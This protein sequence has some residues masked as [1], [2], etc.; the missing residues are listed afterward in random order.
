MLQAGPFTGNFAGCYQCSA[1]YFGTA[2]NHT[3][4]LCEAACWPGH[5]CLEGSTA[6]S[7]C[8]AGTYLPAPG[9]AT[10]ASCIPCAPGSF[11]A[12][13][14]NGNQSCTPC[15]PGTFSSAPRATNCSLCEPGG[16]CASVGAASASMTFEPCPG[17]FHTLHTVITTTSACADP[18]LHHAWQLASTIRTL[19]R[20]A[21]RRAA[22]A[23]PARPTQ[24][25]AAE[26]HLCAQT[27]SQGAS[28][29]Q[30]ARPRALHALLAR[31]RTP[32]AQPYAWNVLRARTVRGGHGSQGRRTPSRTYAT[33]CASRRATWCLATAFISTRG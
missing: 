33:C 23:R 21:S 9:A 11:S 31:I 19:A 24:F 3:S 18:R 4:P 25:P 2:P 26:T 7:P 29:T 27:A 5:F 15:A 22:R 30:R 8:P 10:N 32:L 13:S 17:A 1:G 28:Q 20:E 16:F 14:G 6:P 12:I